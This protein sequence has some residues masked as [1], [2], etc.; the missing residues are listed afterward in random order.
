MPVNRREVLQAGVTGAAFGALARFRVADAAQV[1]SDKYPETFGRIDQFVEQ[2]MRDMNSPGM[3]LV[4][5]DRDGVQRV[6]TYGL[7]DLDRQRELKAD[8]LFHIGSISKSFIALCLMQLRDEGKLDLH[9]PV[10]EYLPW[11]RIDSSFAPIT[12]HHLLTHTSGLAGEQLPVFPS[13][14]A[15]RHLAAYAPGENFHYNNMAFAALGFLA[16]TLDSR[17]APEVIRR[18]IFEPLGM[19]QSEPAITLDIRERVA[20]NYWVFQTDRPYPRHGR[21]SEAPAI[22]L[23]E[24]DGSVAATARD[25]GLYLQMLA[26]GGA[27]PKGRLVSQESFDL[28]SHPHVQ[29]KA[30]GPDASYGYGIA[31]DKLDG[32]TRLRHTG[33]MVS[34]MSA[35]MVDIESGLGAFASINAQQGYRPNPV[36][37]YA[38]RLM[39]A[40]R[41]RKT[42]PALP[43]ADPPTRID[44]AK[45]YAGV[46]SSPSGGKLDVVADKAQLFLVYGGARVPIERSA[47]PELFV[48]R[49]P[50]FQRFMLVFSRKDVKD[51]KSAV[52]E[53]GWGPDWYT[54]SAYQGPTQFSY[55][56]EW[57]SYVGHY[58]NENPWVQ[59]LHVVLRKGRLLL[60]GVIPLEASGERFYLRDEE[61]NPEWVHF[62][63]TVNGKCM[64]IKYSG[65]DLWRVATV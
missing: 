38:I 40:E 41:E 22:I 20:R 25:M 17:E 46:Y 65:E 18:R 15:Y 24:A 57:D 13:D 39:R 63:E 58:R 28:F 31:I 19:A 51:P 7:G 1:G 36:V 42:L 50:D 9:R 56:K 8:E 44:N 47:E 37:Q 10:V 16:W 34:F 32:H 62:G 64:R 2:Y 35:L 60:N 43:A 30:F 12:T 61:H 48:V 33:G 59:S 6:A 52:V 26:S 23:G 45:D 55:P 21:L 29:S 53:A 14:P 54:N 11:F 4:L 49:H 27:A 3:T 5:A